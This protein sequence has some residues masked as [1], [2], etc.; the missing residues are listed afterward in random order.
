MSWCPD[1]EFRGTYRFSFETSV[2]ASLDA[3]APARCA[4]D[5]ARRRAARTYHA[6]SGPLERSL[7]GFHG[8]P[9]RRRLPPGCL[10]G[11]G[12]AG[13]SGVG[14]AAAIGVVCTCLTNV[15]L[16][17]RGVDTAILN[18]VRYRIS[19]EYFLCIHS[20]HTIH[21]I[22]STVSAALLF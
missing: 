7:H 8:Q 16:T 19:T 10:P 21:V 1:F 22:L 18:L 3:I 5:G 9:G 20:G 6:V 15:T 12:R 11:S 13:A 2:R 4:G 14:V 17:G